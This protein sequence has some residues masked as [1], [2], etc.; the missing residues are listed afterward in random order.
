MNSSKVQYFYNHLYKAI[1]PTPVPAGTFPAGSVNNIVVTLCNFL[2]K[3]GQSSQTLIVTSTL[4]PI[5]SIAGSSTL[6]VTT[7]AGL[8]LNGNG[9]SGNKSS[10]SLTFLWSAYENG[11]QKFNII[12]TSKQYYSYK[13]SPY[14]L[15]PGSLYA[16]VLTVFDPTSLL[17]STKT[18]SVNVVQGVIVARLAGGKMITMSEGYNTTLDASASYDTDVLGKCNP[19][20]CQLTATSHICHLHC[21]PESSTYLFVHLF[22]GSSSSAKLSFLWSC[23]QIA[24]TLSSTCSV[25]LP[26]VLTGPKLTVVAGLAAAGSTFFFTVK[27]LRTIALQI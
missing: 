9:Q 14:T 25:L 21:M 4:A 20:T 12:S 3:C 5:V 26:P 6:V 27:F 18:V 24:P 8:T 7:A 17:S 10:A 22:K 19:S 1:P 11:A 16:F 23:V 2:G 13:L 15:K